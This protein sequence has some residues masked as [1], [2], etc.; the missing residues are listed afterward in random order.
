MF[1]TPVLL[2]VVVYGS[3][4]F[5]EMRTVVD[6]ETKCRRVPIEEAEVRG[7]VAWLQE[8]LSTSDN[9]TA[10]FMDVSADGGS[11]AM[12]TEVNGTLFLRECWVERTPG[13]APND[14]RKDQLY[15]AVSLNQAPPFSPQLNLATPLCSEE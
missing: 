13:I 14:I 6:E 3:P 7:E 4:R 11:N 12:V 8:E 15:K 5:L 1:L 2:F 10:P 9:I